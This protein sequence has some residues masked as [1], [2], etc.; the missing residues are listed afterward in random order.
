MKITR[1]KGFTLIELMIGI[2]VA[3]I[4]MA[5]TLSAF[6]SVV[7]SNADYLSMIKIN[8]ELNTVMTVMVRDLKRAG[9][10]GNTTGKTV[11]NQFMDTATGTDISINVGNDCISFSYDLNGDG[12][13]DSSGDADDL[14]GYRYDSTDNAI[15]MRNGASNCAGGGWVNITD[16][17]SI[18]IS[19]LSFTDSSLSLTNSAE[20][21]IRFIEISITGRL[22]NDSS[23]TRTL[24]ERVRVRND[25]P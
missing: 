13:V 7:R 9:Y 19:D 14:F 20:N 8:Q 12:T 4:A 1:Q 16:E 25:R 24:T 22:D 2:V 18:V 11:D 15:E 23:V 17:D 6:I 21:E 3:A 5:A 10:D